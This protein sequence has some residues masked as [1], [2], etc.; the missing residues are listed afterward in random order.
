MLGADARPIRGLYACGNDM[1]SVMGGVYPAPG[2]TIGP[3][4]TFAYVAVRHAAHV[5]VADQVATG[6]AA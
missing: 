2:T 3:G 1:N 5:T 6:V 4:I